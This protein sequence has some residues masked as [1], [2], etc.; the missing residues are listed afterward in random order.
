[1]YQFAKPLAPQDSYHYLHIAQHWYDSNPANDQY[2]FIV[3]FPLYPI[4]IR[5]ITFNFNYINLSALIVSNISSVIALIYLFKLTKLDFDDG[6]AQKAILF[7]SIFP[8]AYFLS[9]IYTEGLFLALIIAS[10][11]Y[12]RREKWPLAGVLGFLAALTRLGGLLMMPVLIVEYLHQKSWNPKKIANLNLLWICLALGG[13]LDL[14]EHK[15]PSHRRR[16]QIC[17]H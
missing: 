16:L 6:V 10:L 13:F 17:D 7:L 4:L 15:L 5:L 14:L 3:F 8:T 9:V 11:Y 1:M 12:A 2:N